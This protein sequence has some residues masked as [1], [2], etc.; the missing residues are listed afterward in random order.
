MVG[1]LMQRCLVLATPSSCSSFKWAA[2]A[3]PVAASAQLLRV[4]GGGRLALVV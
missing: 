2:L 4:C 1:F 3:A